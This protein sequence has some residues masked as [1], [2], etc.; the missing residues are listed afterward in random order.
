MKDK[1]HPGTQHRLPVIIRDAIPGDI[2]AIT[3]IYNHAVEHSTAIWNESTVDAANRMAWLSD[4]RRAGYPVLVAIMDDGSS[5]GEGEVLGY[6]SF[7]D[8]R[9]WDGYR[10]TVEHSVYVHQDQR[11][12]GVGR[13][14]LMALI[15]RAR[16]IG[17][18]VMVAG[19]EAGNN[20]SIRMHEQLGFEQGG[21]MKQ[22]GAKFGRWLDPVFLYLRLDNKAHPDG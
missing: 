2:D 14:L 15:E 11:G 20:G 22:V 17:K 7:A 5:S 12:K 1:T 4:R 18:H 21:H 9:A 13:A 3:A 19:I 10:H 16:A 8:W 6:A